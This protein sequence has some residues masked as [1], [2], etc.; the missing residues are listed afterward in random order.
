MPRGPGIRRYQGV[1]PV[2]IAC[3]K[4]ETKNLLE[5]A[6]IPIPRG[7]IIYDEEDMEMELFG[8]INKQTSL[9][10]AQKKE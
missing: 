4:E 3:D 8:E 9:S 7:T 5:A 10:A 6:S 2:E 1:E